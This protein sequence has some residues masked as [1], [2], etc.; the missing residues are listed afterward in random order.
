[1]TTGEVG[2]VLVG[3]VEGELRE[4]GKNWAQLENLWSNGHL[5]VANNHLIHMGI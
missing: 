4:M 3:G 1:M 5:I 2:A